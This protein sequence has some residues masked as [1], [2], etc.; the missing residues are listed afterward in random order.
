MRAAFD[1]G[2]RC[3]LDR[4]SPLS[5]RPDMNRRRFLPNAVAGAA[6]APVVAAARRIPTIVLLFAGAACLFPPTT[7]S[8]AAQPSEARFD[9]TWDVTITCPDEQAAPADTPIDSSPKSRTA[10][11]ALSTVRRMLQGP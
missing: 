7:A 9:G 4:A 10:S 3:G 2:C 5:Y 8:Q 6:A 1:T 11:C